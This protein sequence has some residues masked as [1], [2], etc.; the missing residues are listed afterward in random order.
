MINFSLEFFLVLVNH[1]TQSIQGFMA[2]T[3]L[4]VITG[5]NFDKFGGGKMKRK[6]TYWYFHRAT[7]WIV[8]GSQCMYI[9]KKKADEFGGLSHHPTRACVR[10]LD[11]MIVSSLCLIH[12][13]SLHG[14][15]HFHLNCTSHWWWLLFHLQSLPACPTAASFFIDNCPIGTIC[16]NNSLLN[17]TGRWQS[18]QQHE[19][20][21]L[22]F[23]SGLQMLLTP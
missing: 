20:R 3:S 1:W 8:Y 9:K 23:V 22:P 14:F 4:S 6:I 15:C 19:A 2:S 11:L 13:E 10:G 7:S 5:K 21:D 12:S 16:S 17:Q 18:K